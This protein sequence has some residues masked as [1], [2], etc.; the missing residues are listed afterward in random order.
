MKNKK[1]V[2]PNRGPLGYLLLIPSSI[3]ILVISFYPLLNGIYLSFTNRNFINPLQND[4]IFLDNYARLMKDSEFFSVLGFTFT[5]TASVVLISYLFGLGL[6]LVLN[7]DMKFR[8]VYRALVLIPW[9]IPSVVVA[10]MWSWILNDQLG[11]LNNTLRNLGIIDKPILFFSTAEMSRISVTFVSAWRAI[12]F[13]AV[14]IL[15]GLQGIPSDMYEAAEI[16]GA[17]FWKSLWYM[18]LPLIKQV[19]FI[20]MT[21]M[22]IWTFNNFEN[23]WLLTRGGPNNATYVLSILSYFTGF[24]RSFISYAATI[25]VMML[26]VM[27][28]LSLL[29]IKLLNIDD[30]DKIVKGEVKN[31]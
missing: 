3:L 16:D 19:S 21:L 5:Y 28:L 29:F 6:A 15:S 24:F 17:G 25:A 9:V 30:I 22:F 10:N 2:G 8:G 26:I 14:T 23:I 11:I 20:S 31:D 7:R 4:F 13:M 18:T 12:P 1:L 27:L